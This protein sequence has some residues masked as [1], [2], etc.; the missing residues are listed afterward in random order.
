MWFSHRRDGDYNKKQTPN[1]HVT[2]SFLF[3]GSAAGF[4]PDNKLRIPGRGVH[5][6]KSTDEIGHIADRGYKFDYVSSAYNSKG[7]KPTRIE[8]IAE[9][10]HR[11]KVLFQVRTADSEKGLKSANWYGAAGIDT[12]FTDR[13]S[14]LRNLPDGRWIQYRVVLDTFNGVH[15]PVIDRVEIAFEQE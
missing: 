14:S 3:W 8:W 4:D 11:S 10:P 15:C 13:G 5:F 2:D 12:Y 6:R 1:E 7:K 9:E